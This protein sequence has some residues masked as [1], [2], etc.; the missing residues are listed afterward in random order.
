MSNTSS[1]LSLNAAT[2]LSNYSRE[3]CLIKELNPESSS[4][5][6]SRQKRVALYKS[7]SLENIDSMTTS[8]DNFSIEKEEIEMLKILGDTDLPVSSSSFGI[9]VSIEI[10]GFTEFIAKLYEKRIPQEIINQTMDVYHF[11]VI[12]FIH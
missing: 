2:F 8:I 6:F 10:V 4:D 9:C 7:L 5:A 11:S 12:I 3:Y 1:L